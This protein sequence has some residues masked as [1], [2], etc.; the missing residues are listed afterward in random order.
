MTDHLSLVAPHVLDGFLNVGNIARKHVGTANCID[1]QG[2]WLVVK[3]FA[4]ILLDVLYTPY[5]VCDTWGRLW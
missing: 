4:D 2:W 1:V 3:N 5:T